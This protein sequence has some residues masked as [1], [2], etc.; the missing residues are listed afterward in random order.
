LY[1]VSS[2]IQNL[3]LAGEILEGAKKYLVISKEMHNF[4]AHLECPLN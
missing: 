2:K 1:S 3:T 4:A